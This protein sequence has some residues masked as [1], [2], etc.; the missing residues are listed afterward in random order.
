MAEDAAYRIQLK[1]YKQL[2]LIL[3]TSYGETLVLDLLKVRLQLYQDIFNSTISGD[4]LITDSV[5]IFPN[6]IP[7]GNDYLRVVLL[8]PAME[9]GESEE[10]PFDKFFRIYKIRDRETKNNDTLIYKLVLCSE[11]LILSKSTQ[12]SRSYKGKKISEII[13]DILEKDLKVSK[14]KINNIQQTSGS[15]DI[16]IPWKKPIEAIQWLTGMAHSDTDGGCFMFFENFKGYTFTSL[17]S[18]YNEEVKFKYQYD[19]KQIDPSIANNIR[20][21]DLY[22][23]TNDYDLL[24]NMENGGYASKLL[25]VD[26]FSQAHTNY[27]FDL[28]KAEQDLLNDFKPIEDF[29]LKT[30]ESSL[31]AYNT[32]FNTYIQVKGSS[33]EKENYVDKWFQQRALHITMLHNN[34]IRV[35]APGELGMNVGDIVEF[36][37]PAAGPEQ[38]TS[39]FDE[40][41]T[42]K[43]IVTA[44]NHRFFEGNF[45]TL[46]ELS[47]DSLNSPLPPAQ[48]LTGVIK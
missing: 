45:E 10:V 19:I 21:P 22:Q 26:L 37:F 32:K 33:T 25:A 4:L 14:D 35:L 5:G 6:Y 16:V 9:N 36:S 27:E 34:R 30:G 18:L 7:S 24:M 13:S 41:R 11:E 40:Y 3:Y 29:Q 39:G 8:Q 23:I 15:Y 2:G 31:K 12:I 20:T 38:T 47:S 43:Y 44:I 48:D 1:D 28:A 17:S 46:F 42:G